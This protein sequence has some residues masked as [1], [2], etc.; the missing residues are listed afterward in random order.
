MIAGFI[1]GLS[2]GLLIAMFVYLIMDAKIYELKNRYTSALKL[3]TM[4]WRDLT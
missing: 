3:S 4:K 2:I 1:F